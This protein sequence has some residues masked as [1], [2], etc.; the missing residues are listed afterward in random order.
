MY[1]RALAAM[2][3]KGGGLGPVV[4]SSKGVPMLSQYWVVANRA[5]EAMLRLAADLG[6]NAVAYQ[7]VETLQLDLFAEPLDGAGAAEP[8][9]PFGAFRRGS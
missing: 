4:K 7:R 6:L 9:T 2:R 1:I 3:R 5:H 8:A